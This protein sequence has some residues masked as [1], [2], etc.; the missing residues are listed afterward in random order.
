MLLR[1]KFYLYDYQPDDH[2]QAFLIDHSHSHFPFLFPKILLLYG[3]RLG[4]RPDIMVLE[5]N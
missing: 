5:C 4:R 3:V 2:Y 1:Y